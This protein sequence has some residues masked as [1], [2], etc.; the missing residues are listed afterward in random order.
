MRALTSTLRPTAALRRL[1]VQLAFVALLVAALMPT[2]SRLMQPVGL[3]DWAT[4]C[5][6]TPAAAGSGAPQGEQHEPGDAC[7]LCSLAHTTPTLGGA[8]MPAV[9]VLAYAPPAPPATAQV[10]AGV[11]QAR[12]PSARAPPFLA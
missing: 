1:G 9:A 4:I 10:H 2:L 8:A 12:A 6:A 11:A 5:Q 7:A 3:S